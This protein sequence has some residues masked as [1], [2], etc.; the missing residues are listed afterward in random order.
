[1]IFLLFYGISLSKWRNL[2]IIM[3]ICHYTFKTWTFLCSEASNIS[4]EGLE[5]FWGK[6]PLSSQD[7][8]PQEKITP[9]RK[10]LTYLINKVPLVAFRGVAARFKIEFFDFHFKVGLLVYII[11]KEI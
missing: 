1:M 9:F 3:S 8:S 6:V 7:K 5:L 11:W 10:K 4:R 2:C